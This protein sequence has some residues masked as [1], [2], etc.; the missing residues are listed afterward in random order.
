[1]PRHDGSD[2][3]IATFP[4]SMATLRITQQKLAKEFGV[5]IAAQYDTP[6]KTPRHSLR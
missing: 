5:V 6:G 1:M 3:Q 4:C 2:Q